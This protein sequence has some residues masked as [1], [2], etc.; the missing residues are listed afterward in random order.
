MSDCSNLIVVPS[1]WW[2]DQ[3]RVD[4]SRHGIRNLD[5]AFKLDLM[6]NYA[7]LKYDQ[8]WDHDSVRE[9]I[10]MTS[11]TYYTLYFICKQL[12]MQTNIN[13]RILVVIINM[14]FM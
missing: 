4:Q 5:S 6:Y 2:L 11:G 13:K 10:Y 8:C 7:D 1:L 9:S 12:S 3:Q 14:N